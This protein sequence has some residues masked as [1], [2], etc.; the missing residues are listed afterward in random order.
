MDSL[1]LSPGSRMESFVLFGGLLLFALIET[2]RPLRLPNLSTPQRWL[3]HGVLFALNTG[4]G[5]LLFRGGAVV[6]A[7][8]AHD[9]GYGIFHRFQL[10]YAAQFIAGFALVDLAHYASHYSYHRIPVL[11]RIHRVHHADPDYDVTTGFRFHPMEALLTQALVFGLIAAFGL[12]AMAVLA[13]ETVT[14]FQDLFEHANI[15]IPAR[16]DRF[17]RLL[18]ITP[19]MHRVH[20]S[21]DIA[22]QSSN[23]GTILTWWDRLFRTYTS[24]PA[25]P[26]DEMETGLEGYPPEESLRVMD[27]LRMP[28]GSLKNDVLIRQN[29][30]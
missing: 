17:L 1:G 28:F 9:R 30:R 22:E 29:E 4:L 12:P 26:L 8:F 25:V 20:H 14:A 21:V 15:E 27:T 18:L 7:A 3:N 11:W 24:G 16:V 5:T 10:P 19:N 2:F 13:A 6:F 23:F